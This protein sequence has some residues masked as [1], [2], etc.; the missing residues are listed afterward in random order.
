M[1]VSV[2]TLFMFDSVWAG[3][4]YRW[5]LALDN[6]ATRRKLSI[7]D[8]GRALAR[9]ND[10]VSMREVARRMQ[11]SHSDIQRLQERFRA[12]GS[13]TDQPRFGRPCCSSRQDDRLLRISTLRDQSITP[14]TLRC[15][16]MN[17]ASV[18]VSVRGQFAAVFL[19]QGCTQ[20]V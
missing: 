15:Q 13:A 12:T 16:L 19:K 4:K 5:N 8:R 6:H 2:I 17:A 18:N 7:L 9:L 3:V 14:I 10:G 1:R 20:G 11:V